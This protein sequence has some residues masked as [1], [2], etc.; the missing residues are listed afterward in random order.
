MSYV[1][2]KTMYAATYKEIILGF[3]V[4][5][6]ILIILYPRD[7]LT[8]QVL[9]EQ[10]NYD[11]SMLY[12]QNMVNND[13]SNESLMLSLAKQAYKAGKKDLSFRLL[14]LL[15]NSK[16]TN[17]RS[18]SYWLSYEIAK[19]DYYYFKKYKKTKEQNAKL[20]EMQ[21]IYN[22]ILDEHFYTNDE[23]QMLYKESY[24][25]NDKIHGFFLLQQL[26]KENPNDIKLLTDAYYISSDLKKYDKSME[27]LDR[28][29]ILDTT[30][31]EKWLEQRYFLIVTTYKYNKAES[32]IIAHA[33]HSKFWANKLHRFYLDH[34][35]YKKASGLYM[36]AFHKA[37]PLSAQRELWL[38]AINT[39]RAGNLNRDALRLAYKY[40][41]Y[42]LRDK[43]AR[44][45]LLKLYIALNDLNRANSL[46]K[47]IL[48]IKR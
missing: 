47:K 7:I 12:L 36:N 28:L 40:E 32:Y 13:P 27:Y 20:Q 15:N 6:I 9:A 24:F 22:T 2:H 38:K 29:S 26:L 30:H 44:I 25:L 46:S 34:K 16:D 18:K 33:Q 39:L 41:N 17:I 19:E 45:E 37:S 35:K 11:L 3:I 23:V 1:D 43:K 10:S 31:Q 42:F 5:S 4:F 8:K 21:I 14:H 48:R